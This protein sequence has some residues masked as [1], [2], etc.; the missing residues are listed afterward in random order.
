LVPVT[1][2]RGERGPP[3]NKRASELEELEALQQ[4]SE[5][6]E[7]TTGW[8]DFSRKREREETG[9]AANLHQ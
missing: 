6:E 2:R 4:R 7:T 1:A 5:E 3:E 8:R 9:A